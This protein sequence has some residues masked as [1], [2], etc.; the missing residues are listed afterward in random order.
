[1]NIIKMEHTQ[2]TEDIR[3]ISKRKIRKLVGKPAYHGDIIDCKGTFWGNC[4][5]RTHNFCIN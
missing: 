5:D 2:F 4:E 3:K 1:M